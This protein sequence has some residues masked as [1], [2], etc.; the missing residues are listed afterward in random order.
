MPLPEEIIPSKV[1]ANLENSILRVDLPK[2]N[3]KD[4]ESK[5][6]RVEVK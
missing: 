3:P 5:A 2:K 1:S 6:T 4:S